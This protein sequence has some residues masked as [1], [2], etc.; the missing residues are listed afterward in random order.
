MYF[1]I[2]FRGLS[3]RCFSGKTAAK[4]LSTTNKAFNLCV[5]MCFRRAFVLWRERKKRVIVVVN[6]FW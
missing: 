1:D 3:T 5:W 4:L 2:D 6:A